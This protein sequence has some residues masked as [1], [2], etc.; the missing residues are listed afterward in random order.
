MTHRQFTST[1]IIYFNMV[2][3]SHDIQNHHHP[4]AL[5][6]PGYPK[7]LL[8]NSTKLNFSGRRQSC[9]AHTSDDTRCF[10]WTQ[11]LPNEEISICV[12]DCCWH[13]YVYV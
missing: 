3:I 7:A 6:S 8:F 13:N 1:A 9:E 11:I 10:N 2:F 12:A 4:S 5:C